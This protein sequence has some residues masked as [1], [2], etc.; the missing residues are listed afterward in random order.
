M[1]QLNKTGSNQP[2]INRSVNNL[3]VSKQGVTCEVRQIP[4]CKGIKRLIKDRK[5][6]KIF[7]KMIN[8]SERERERERERDRE[9]ERRQEAI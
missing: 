5:D 6:V 1:A 9:R 3:I 2:D 8:R 7:L 4:Y